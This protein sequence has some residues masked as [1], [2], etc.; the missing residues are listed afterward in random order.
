MLRRGSLQRIHRCV[1]AVGHRNLSRF[2]WWTAAAFS[3]GP[4]SVLSHRPAGA[5]WALREWSGRHAITTPTWRRGH[6]GTEAH[7]SRLPGDERAVL[8]GLPITSVPRTLLDLATVLQPHELLNAINQAEIKGL[9]DPLSLPALLERHRGERGTGVLRSALEDAGYGVTAS[10]LEARFARFVS[11]RR[12]PRPELNAWVR[13]GDVSYS[14]D[15]LWRSRC[16][17]V[18][19][20]SARFHSSAPA[21]TREATRDRRLLLAGW[22]VI[23]VTWAQLKSASQADELERDLRAALRG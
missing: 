11:E 16:L 1:Y 18:E 22:R 10:E 12:L 14:P 21:V 5:A 7:C 3:G 20:H 9:A 19:L 17:I 6:G 23:H 13:V 8:D 4:G 2:G 15:C